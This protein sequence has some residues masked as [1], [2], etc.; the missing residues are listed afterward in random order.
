MPA[1]LKPL[2]RAQKYFLN[3]RNLEAPFLYIIIEQGILQHHSTFKRHYER[4]MTVVA[5]L[6][7]SVVRDTGLVITPGQSRSHRAEPAVLE[8][9]G[10]LSVW[11]DR[12][13]Q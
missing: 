2:F 11:P 1:S 6:M 5:D 10:T 3:F 12:L 7:K 13:L 4:I 8:F 9:T